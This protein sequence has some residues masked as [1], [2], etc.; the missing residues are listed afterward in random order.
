MQLGESMPGDTAEVSAETLQQVFS[1]RS[2]ARLSHWIRTAPISHLLRRTPPA[3]LSDLDLVDLEATA[4]P[5]TEAIIA[6]WMVDRFSET[7]L[8]AWATDSLRLEWQYV[9]ALRPGCT[10]AASMRERPADREALAS[11]LADQ[12]VSQ[13]EHGNEG[14]HAESVLRLEVAQ[15]LSVALRALREGRRQDAVGLYRGFSEIDPENAEIQNNLGFCLLPDDPEAA[16][17]HLLIAAADDDFYGQAASYAN[18]ALA[19]LLTD[20]LEDAFAALDNARDLA[21]STDVVW[22]WPIEPPRDRP[23][24]QIALEEYLEALDQAIVMKVLE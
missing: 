1:P 13:W 4:P 10:S 20:R 7:Y 23:T 21:D 22:M 15:F 5:G 14:G 2:F 17:E 6:R 19:F 9:H 12:S 24:E 18:L 16:I 8:N 11:E 3:P